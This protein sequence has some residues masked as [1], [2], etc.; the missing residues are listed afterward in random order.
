MSAPG[1]NN[2]QPESVA[3]LSRFVGYMFAGFE[4]QLNEIT[5][6]LD[7]MEVVTKDQHR[8]DIEDLKEELRE[9]KKE[10]EDYQNKLAAYAKWFVSSL[11]LP[12][13]GLAVTIYGLLNGGS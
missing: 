6:K 9:Q 8:S 13:A 12:L 2:F 3:E 4:K 5:S 1:G 11:I 7:R 10:I